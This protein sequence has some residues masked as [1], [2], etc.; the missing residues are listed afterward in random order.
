MNQSDSLVVQDRVRTDR[1]MLWLLLAHV[2][3]VGLLVPIGYGTHSFAIF[4]SLAVGALAAAA[5]GLLRGTRG[6]SVVFA[7][8]RGL[9]GADA[10][11]D[12]QLWL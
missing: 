7:A 10:V 4:A 5:Y 2:P 3:V 9:G 8:R 11:D 6:C 1:Q 12:L